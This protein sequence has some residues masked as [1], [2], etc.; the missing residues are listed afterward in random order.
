M[1][2]QHPFARWLLLCL[3]PLWLA[4]GGAEVS[5]DADRLNQLFER[6]TLK[7]A[8]PD[9]RVHSFNVWLAADDQ[10]RQLG[11][12]YVRQLDANA[13]MLFIYPEPFRIGMWMKNTFLSLD[14]LFVDPKGKVVQVVERTTP[15]SLKTISAN[16]AVLG[17]I[18][19]NAGTAERLRIRP[20]SRVMHAAFGTSAAK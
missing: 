1:N 9:A 17:V 8:T 19:L 5:S 18:E 7:I 6:S 3:A 16:T 20:G 13:G 11:L 4:S 2:R 14:M 10:H 12:M 15:Q